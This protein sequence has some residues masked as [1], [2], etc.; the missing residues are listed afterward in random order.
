MG[1]EGAMRPP[2]EHRSAGP[3]GRPPGPAWASRPRAMPQPRPQEAPRV[4]DGAGAGPR[5]GAPPT[6]GSTAPLVVLCSTGEDVV[7]ELGAI[8]ARFP[9]AACVV[10]CPRP[11]LEVARTA[12]SAGARGVVHAGVPPEQL[13]RAMDVD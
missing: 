12:L 8:R 1:A 11:E 6:E 7:S 9:E 3:D 5:T 13:D 4:E 10:L 2:A